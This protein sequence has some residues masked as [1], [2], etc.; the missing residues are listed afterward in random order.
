MRLTLSRAAL[1]LSAILMLF[2]SGCFRQAGEAIAPTATGQE[3]IAITRE[4]PEGMVALPSGETPDTVVLTNEPQATSAPGLIEPTTEATVSIIIPT[5]TVA[6]IILT[7]TPQYIT[8]QMPLDF[9]TPDT[10]APTM[11]PAVDT[12]GLT[13]TPGGPQS[14]I[15]PNPSDMLATP[16]NLPGVDDPCAYIIQS[17]DTL[18]AI[19]LNNGFTVAELIAANPDL[20]DSSA[21]I[22][23][24]DPLALPLPDCV[25]AEATPDA[26]GNL[27]FATRAPTVAPTSTQ[28]RPDGTQIHVVQPGDVLVN[29]A[30]RYG[31]TVS[32]IVQAN[33][34]SNPNALQVGQELIIPAR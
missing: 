28:A 4:Q 30:T 18:Y 10:P 32:A 2:T 20:G 29:I 5:S 16:T 34:L 22:Q 8:P 11:A 26:E 6:L 31:T 27:P 3:Q 14:F 17:G 1:S 21:V 15:L 33:N 13:G 23:P 19:A 7:S 24:G 25:G 12:V 9:T